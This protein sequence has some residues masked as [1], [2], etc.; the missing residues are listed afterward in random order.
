MSFSG[1]VVIVI[2]TE[3]VGFT[4]DEESGVI[5]DAITESTLTLTM[6]GTWVEPGTGAFNVDAQVTPID[7]AN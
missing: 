1:T 6:K 4:F 2:D 3:I 7:V 5:Q